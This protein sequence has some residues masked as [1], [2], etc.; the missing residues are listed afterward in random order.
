MRVAEAS[1]FAISTHIRSTFSAH[2]YTI[3]ALE[4]AR[5]VEGNEVSSK[6]PPALKSSTS[7]SNSAT[8]NQKTLLGFFAKHNDRAATTP[9]PA[10]DFRQ[11]RAAPDAVLSSGVRQS[12]N[13]AL[14]PAP[15]SDAVQ[16]SSPISAI[17]SAP[18]LK[19]SGLLSPAS[20]DRDDIADEPTCKD[21]AQTELGSPSRKVE[22][23]P[24]QLAQ[25]TD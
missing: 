3:L 5:G 15:S 7:S 16:A 13:A 6:K 14:T 9:T 10:N 17:K 23:R 20:S 18:A 4:M 24:C 12:S 21:T 25:V 2:C 1:P 22:A 19:K 11:N 8:K